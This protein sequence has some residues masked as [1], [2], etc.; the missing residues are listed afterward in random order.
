MECSVPI[1]LL[2][3]YVIMS[4]VRG[5]NKIFV[6]NVAGNRCCLPCLGTRCVLRCEELDT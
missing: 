3:L 4:G 5:G 6:Q 1:V 2:A